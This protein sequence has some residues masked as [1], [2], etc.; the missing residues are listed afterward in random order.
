MLLHR[1]FIPMS[2]SR[3][4]SKVLGRETFNPPNVPWFAGENPWKISISARLRT[5]EGPALRD[6]P[7]DGAQ[8]DWL[9]RSDAPWPP[10]AGMDKK[11]WNLME[12]WNNPKRC[13]KMM[14]GLRC[15]HWSVLAGLAVFSISI[16]SV[17]V[18]F[19][20]VLSMSMTCFHMFSQHCL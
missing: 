15:W 13:G 4:Y 17:S 8:R 14:V 20:K 2:F 6:L 9:S 5:R 3:I 10:T 7:K 18:V 12:I 19:Y 16:Y 11:G 1:S